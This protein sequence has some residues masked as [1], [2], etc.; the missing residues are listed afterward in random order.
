VSNVAADPSPRDALFTPLRAPNA[1]ELIVRRIGEA[2]GSGVLAPGER[3]P[4][5]LELATMLAVAPMTLRQAIAILR[6][7]GLL[8]TRRGKHGGSFVSLNVIDA[9]AAGSH[10]I[11]EPALREL[12]DWRRAVSGEAAALAAVRIDAR[13]LEL[14]DRLAEAVEAQAAGSFPDFR[15]ADSR[16]HLAI[17]GAS[18][19]RRLVAAETAIQSEL[20]TVLAAIPA[21]IRARRA[22]TV[23]H[24]PIVS[25]IHDRDADAARAA[26]IRHVESTYDWVVG[27]SV[28]GSGQS[29]SSARRTVM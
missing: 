12:G 17:A 15:L 1:S 29:P 9:L 26:T 3:L 10:R 20:G 14:L 4:S 6:E 22:S 11:D 28:A 7:A 16:F 23:G 2:I 8:E 24:G 18:G 27:L 19:S 13:Q 5:E 25:A 21:P